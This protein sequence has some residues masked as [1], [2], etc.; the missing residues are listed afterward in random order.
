M[1]KAS[2][3]K[4]A[5]RLKSAVEFPARRA[6]GSA[7]ARLLDDALACLNNIA[8]EYSKLCDVMLKMPERATEL[9]EGKRIMNALESLR[10]KLLKRKSSNS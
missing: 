5:M 3:Y 10:A 8:G 7:E 1:L 4:A 6:S 9:K 2:E